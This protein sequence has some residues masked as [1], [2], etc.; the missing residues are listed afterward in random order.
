MSETVKHF[1]LI[2]AIVDSDT[3]KITLTRGASGAKHEL[4]INT[5][6]GCL[7]WARKSLSKKYP[8]FEILAEV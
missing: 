3:H 8:D 4:S 7:D 6:E 2:K 1:G 5:L